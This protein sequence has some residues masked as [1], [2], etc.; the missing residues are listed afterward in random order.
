MPVTIINQPTYATARSN[1]IVGL[2]V[3]L[4]GKTLRPTSEPGP[5]NALDSKPW[6][7]ERSYDFTIDRLSA[8]DLPT[9]WSNREKW[10]PLYVKRNSSKSKRL[11]VYY[12]G[13]G[14]VN[15]MITPQWHMI[16]LLANKLNADIMIQTY[17]MVPHGSIHDNV[18][19]LTF[20]YQKCRDIAKQEGQEL[21]ICGDR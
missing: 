17:V 13:G 19:K 16:G 7:F 10:P 4:A 2:L 15:A 5:S 11:L 9:E 20:L 6:G 18:D 12:H 14:F 3:S 8:D 21:I 1:W